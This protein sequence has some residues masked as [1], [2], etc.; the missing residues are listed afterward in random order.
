MIMTWRFKYIFFIIKKEHFNVIHL[1]DLKQITFKYE[2][3]TMYLYAFA[4]F[5]CLIKN[6]ITLYQNEFH[7][8]KIQCT[9]FY[10][11]SIY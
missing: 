2:E 11:A 4:Y 3:I 1:K 9:Q 6:I 10:F 8:S 7:N 5:Y